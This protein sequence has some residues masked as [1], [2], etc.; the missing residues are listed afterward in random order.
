MVPF[1]ARDFISL[2]RSQ[3]MKTKI[4]AE[5]SVYVAGRQPCGSIG[6]KSHSCLA[7]SG[8]C[9]LLAS[10]TSLLLLPGTAHGIWSNGGFENGPAN[11]APPG[12]TVTSYLNKTGI[13]PQVPQTFAGLNLSSGGHSQDGDSEFADGI[14]H[15][16]R[17]DVGH[18]R[19]ATVA[20]L[21]QP[22]RAG[23]S[24]GQQPE[25]QRLVS[26]RDH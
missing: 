18:L 13:T 10:F 8:I 25:R 16:A 11:A 15:A 7:A 1:G 23:Q 24:I 21:W 19:V 12:W 9:R 3:V 17:R 4:S 6:R 26:V 2:L 5:P 22:V 14:R 20:A